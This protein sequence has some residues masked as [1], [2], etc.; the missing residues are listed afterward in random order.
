MSALDI[1]LASVALL[2]ACALALAGMYTDARHRQ[3]PHWIPGGLVLLWAM[4][5]YWAPDSLGIAP[6]AALACGVA[7]LLA[8]FGFHALGWL[9]GGDGKLLAALALWLGHQRLGPWLLGVAAIGLLFAIAATIRGDS[10]LRTRGIPFAW[11]IVPP[12][13][14]LLLAQ[15]N[16]LERVTR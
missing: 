1:R 14:A 6:V 8:G 15:A 12:G 5:V 4:T 16:E 7:G 2:A 13:V 10:G 3:I 9:G 11:A